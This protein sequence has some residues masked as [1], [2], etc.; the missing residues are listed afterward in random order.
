MNGK[1][2]FCLKI[3]TKQHNGSNMT[4]VWNCGTVV[5]L[6]KKCQIIR[7]RYRGVVIDLALVVKAVNHS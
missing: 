2:P 1:N 4:V 5:V 6:E 7:V 3:M